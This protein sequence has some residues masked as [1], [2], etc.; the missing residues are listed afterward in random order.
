VH[1]H[2]GDSLPYDLDAELAGLDDDPLLRHLA[3]SHSHLY[4][5]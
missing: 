4:I 3:S 5:L 1:E 2:K